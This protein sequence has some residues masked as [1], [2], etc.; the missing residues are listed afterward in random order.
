MKKILFTLIMLI[1]TLSL[2][3]HDFEV[4][5]IYYNYLDKTTKTIKV[6]RGSTKYTGSVIIPSSVTYGGVTYSVTEIGG[7]AFYYCTGLT[8]V[9][10]PNSVTKIDYDAFR[11]SGLTSVTIPNS[12]T[13]IV[14]GTFQSCSGLTEVTIPNSVTSIGDYAFFNCSGLT[15]VTIPNSVTSIGSLAFCE[16]TG[17]TSVT[18]PNSVTEIGESAFSRCTGLTEVTIPN[19]VTE[20][21]ESAFYRCSSLTSVTVPN[22]VT[23]IGKSAF[24]GT[25]WRENHADGVIY[26]GKVL[27]EYKGIMPKNTT[28]NIKEG[29]VSISPYAFANCTGLTEVTIPNSVTE[30]GE[31]AFDGCTGLTSIDYN[32]ENC[33]SIDSSFLKGYTGTFKIGDNVKSIPA[34]IL[35]RADVSAIEMGSSVEKIGRCAFRFCNRLSTVSLPATIKEID[36]YAFESCDSLVSIV[37]LSPTPPTMITAQLTNDYT[38]TL[39]VPQ[40]SYELYKNDWHWG[41]FENIVELV[42]TEDRNTTFAMPQVTDAVAYTVNVYADEAKTQLVATADL[43]AEETATSKLKPLHLSIDGFENGRY[44]YDVMAQFATGKTLRNHFGSFAVGNNGID[45]IETDSDAIEIARYDIHGRL[46]SAPTPGINIVK[47]SDGTTR[48]ECV[49]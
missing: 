5:G 35:C 3:A 15:E 17:L 30:I 13:S 1:A 38:P 44:Y 27:Y 7:L 40:G 21:G 37:S 22:S 2:H 49:K 4:D 25:P 45:N 23:S 29:I 26:I 10:I 20:I 46:L 12:V 39:Y 16:C 6:T 34:F 33:T 19:S 8:S 48:K 31:H 36:Y 18:I 11:G 47:Y 43:D 14:S 41:D 28:I 9:T 32:A 24:Y 42:E